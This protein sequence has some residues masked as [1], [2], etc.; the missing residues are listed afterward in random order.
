MLLAESP[1]VEVVDR[2]RPRGPRILR[3]QPVAAPF[4][5]KPRLVLPGLMHATV[6]PDLEL[7]P[8]SESSFDL[9]LPELPFAS[10]PASSY[11][12]PTLHRLLDRL[13]AYGS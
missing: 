3:R 4:R 7:V 5:A 11:D 2:C 8:I 10:I 12:G 13:Q 1:A 6:L 9:S